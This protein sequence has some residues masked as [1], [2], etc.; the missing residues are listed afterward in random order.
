MKSKQVGKCIIIVIGEGRVG[1]SSIISRFD[2][3]TF[4]QNTLITLGVDFREK[5]ITLKNKKEISLKIFD[6]AGQER[7]Q[8]ITKS[9]YKKANGAFIVYSINDNT[10]FERV[11][12]WLEQVKE[13]SPE[14]TTIYLIGNKCDDEKNRVVPK[15]K[16]EE[17]AKKYNIKFYETSAKNNI[18]VNTFFM[19]IANEICVKKEGVNSSNSV[20]LDKTMV[21]KNEKKGCC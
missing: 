13:N 18:N 7:Y 17:L 15:S 11:S 14:S 19:D 1:K 12:H 9:F 21:K 2:S 10:S 6:T 20:I 4:T 16:G 8:T 3:N 5:T